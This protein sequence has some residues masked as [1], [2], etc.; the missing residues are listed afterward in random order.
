MPGIFYYLT[1][2]GGV[3]LFRQALSGLEVVALVALVVGLAYLPFIGIMGVHLIGHWARK[4][5]TGESDAWTL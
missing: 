4:L 2:S 5:W 3:P 1:Q